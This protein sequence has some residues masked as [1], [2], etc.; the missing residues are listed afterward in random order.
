M[1][2]AY[3]VILA[4]IVAKRSIDGMGVKSVKDWDRYVWTS[5]MHQ[6]FMQLG[7]SA[8]MMNLVNADQIADRIDVGECQTSPAE[9]GK[10][11]LNLARRMPSPEMLKQA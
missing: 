4:G 8:T 11:L 1:A 5:E 7:K 10:K 9:A 3:G 2:D 6:T